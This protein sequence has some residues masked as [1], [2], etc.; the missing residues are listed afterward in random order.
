MGKNRRAGPKIFVYSR[1]ANLG[2]FLPKKG[3]LGIVLGKMFLAFFI[4][5][6]G[7]L[8]SKSDFL[9]FGL[10]ALFS[11]FRYFALQRTPKCTKRRTVHIVFKF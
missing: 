6:S 2:D 4:P 8:K 1:V 10:A 9:K 7:I 3:N 11:P 5:I